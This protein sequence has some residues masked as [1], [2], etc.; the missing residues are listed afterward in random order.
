MSMSFKFWELNFGA[1]IE[2]LSKLLENVIRNLGYTLFCN[3]KHCIRNTN[4]KWLF[5]RNLINNISHYHQYMDWQDEILFEYVACLCHFTHISLAHFCLFYLFARDTNRLFKICVCL[6]NILQN[7]I[8]VRYVAFV[9]FSLSIQFY[10]KLI[11][12][13]GAQAHIQNY[14]S[15]ERERERY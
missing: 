9:M 13:A 3:A 1:F 4:R 5:V 15:R 11:T 6:E 14:N 10:A 8:R 7:F 2:C 12:F